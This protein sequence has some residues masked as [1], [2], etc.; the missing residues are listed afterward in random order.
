MRTIRFSLT[1]DELVIGRALLSQ[2]AAFSIGKA[3][4]GGP[5]AFVYVNGQHIGTVGGLSV[6]SLLRNIT[7]IAEQ[8]REIDAAGRA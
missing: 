2:N 8:T 4:D 6:P 3:P 5:V 7:Y 1:K